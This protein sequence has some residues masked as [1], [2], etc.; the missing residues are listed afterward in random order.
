MLPLFIFHIAVTIGLEILSWDEKVF[1][2]V[3]A[4]P[5]DATLELFIKLLLFIL[6]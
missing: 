3:K 4:S 2:Y 5:K 1:S 6:N